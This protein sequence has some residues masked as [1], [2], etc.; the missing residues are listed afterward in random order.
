MGEPALLE[1]LVALLTLTLLEII[2]G[3]DNILVLAIMT[4]RLPAHQQ[5]RGRFV[6][7]GLAML[8]R[9]ALLVFVK[10]LIGLTAPWV[11]VLGKPFSGRDVILIAGGL[12]LLVKAVM[13][14]HKTVEGGGTEH[15]SKRAVAA[16]FLW[17]MI[18]IALLDLVFSL[19]SV[20][21]AVG[22]AR[23]LWVMITAIVLAIIIMM[24]FAAPISRFI[25]DHPTMKTL[26]LAFLLLIAV[27]LIIEGYAEGEEEH[28]KKA[29]LYFAMGFS[30]FVELLNLRLLK[31]QTRRIRP[32][33]GS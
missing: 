31:R 26:A 33:A 29:Y 7:L 24:V 21:T 9:I 22:M 27:T 19:D 4:D 6:G 15:A 8:M 1:S 2:L 32:A 14:L 25:H 12:F 11:T 5:P 18:Q 28:V 20:I 3:I 30:L 16:G 13:E 23:E 10:A 17:T